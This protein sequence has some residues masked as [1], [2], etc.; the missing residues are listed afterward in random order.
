MRTQSPPK[1]KI[2]TRIT[3]VFG[4]PMAQLNRSAMWSA[5]V[6]AASMSLFTHPSPTK[7]THINMHT[8]SHIHKHKHTLTHIYSHQHTPSLSHT[9]IYSLSLSLSF[10]LSLIHILSH[11]QTHTLSQIHTYTQT[12][13]TT[14]VPNS[15]TQNTIITIK[16]KPAMN[17]LKV[18]D[19]PTLEKNNFIFRHGNYCPTLPEVKRGLNKL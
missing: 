19:E 14:C 6:S 15:E 5:S 3:R 1:K 8:Y 9:Y 10:S 16:R 18:Y 7:L 17:N 12:Y 2:R 11:K 13:N 4:G